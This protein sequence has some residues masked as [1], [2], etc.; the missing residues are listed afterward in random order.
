MIFPMELLQNDAQ[1]KREFVSIENTFQ[2]VYNF[3]LVTCNLQCICCLDRTG[4]IIIR[5][6]KH[7]ISFLEGLYNYALLHEYSN[8]STRFFTVYYWKLYWPLLEIGCGLWFLLSIII[9]YF[10]TMETARQIIHHWIRQIYIVLIYAC[11]F[12]LVHSYILWIIVINHHLVPD[13]D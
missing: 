13:D 7:L 2:L 9:L 12:F 6:I 4:T 1:H 8:I 5:L 10:H 3:Q 11:T